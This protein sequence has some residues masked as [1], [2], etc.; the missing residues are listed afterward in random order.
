MEEEIILLII[1]TNFLGTD[2]KHT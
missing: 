2:L 1:Q